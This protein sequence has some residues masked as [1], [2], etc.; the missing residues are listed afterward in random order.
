MTNERKTKKRTPREA[1]KAKPKAAPARTR[2]P[3]AAPTRAKA[4]TMAAGRDKVAEKTAARNEAP[5]AQAK[6]ATRRRSAKQAAKQAPEAFEVAA[7][8]TVSGMTPIE[9]PRSHGTPIPAPSL[10]G[11]APVEFAKEDAVPTVKAAVQRG[12]EAA[13]TGMNALFGAG[14]DQARQAYAQVQATGETLRQAMTESAAA[15][16]RGAIEINTKVLDL[17]RAQSEATLALWRS[18]FTAGSL[19][20]AIEQQSSAA[21]QAYETAALHWKDLADATGR[22]LGDVAKPLRTTW[23]DAGR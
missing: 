10:R 3:K 11:S 1:A 21:R 4:K 13:S 22:W 20:E 14:T 18:A 17:V 23:T 5:R 7:A 16:T 2:A 15:T 9:P 12:A 8:A 19:S 6:T